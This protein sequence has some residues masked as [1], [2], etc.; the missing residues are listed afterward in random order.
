MKKPDLHFGDIIADYRDAELM[1][2]IGFNE[3]ACRVFT[4]VSGGGSI[5]LGRADNYDR[6]LSSFDPQ[7]DG[8]YKLDEDET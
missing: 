3:D 6:P 4:L 7:F 8:Y 2:F 1:M 5:S